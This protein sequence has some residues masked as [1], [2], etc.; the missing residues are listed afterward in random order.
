VPLKISIITS[1]INTIETVNVILFHL[2]VSLICHIV[3]FVHTT[4]LAVE[5]GQHFIRVIVVTG[6]RGSVVVKALR[7]KPGRGFDSR[8]FHW[9]FSVTIIPVP[10]WPWG[11]LSL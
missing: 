5:I 4:D 2:T 6:A 1:I 8:W 10:L 9:N 3:L 11:R 7:Y